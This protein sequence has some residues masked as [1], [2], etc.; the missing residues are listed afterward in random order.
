ME[1]QIKLL[2]YLPESNKI[3][4]QELIEQQK[5]SLAS[6]IHDEKKIIKIEQSCEVTHENQLV[7]KKN[8]N[9]KKCDIISLNL[10]VDK[11]IIIIDNN[12]SSEVLEVLG[13]FDRSKKIIN[14]RLSLIGPCIKHNKKTFDVKNYKQ[15]NDTELNFEI[16]SIPFYKNFDKGELF[17]SNIKKAEYIINTNSCGVK[18][19]RNI[20]VYPDIEITIDVPVS[21]S[22][23]KEITQKITNSKKNAHI[24][25]DKT[26]ELK[27]EAKYKEDG[28][29]WTISPSIQDKFK[30]I[31]DFK[32][33]ADNAFGALQLAFDKTIEIKFE[34]PRGLIHFD[35]KYKNKASPFKVGYEW[36]AQFNLD[37]LI[38]ASA[39]IQLDELFLKTC[40]GPI[41]AL[42]AKIKQALSH[43]NIEVKLELIVTGIL[44]I[45][46]GLKKEISNDTEKGIQG[47]AGITGKI[48]ADLK[49]SGELKIQL[50]I[51]AI[52]VSA[53][54]GAKTGIEA[55]GGIYQNSKNLGL[56]LTLKFLGVTFYFEFKG[57]GGIQSRP[58]NTKDIKDKPLDV[59]KENEITVGEEEWFK[60]IPIS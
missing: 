25:N 29:E 24:Y 16:P 35:Y 2:E 59:S 27:L 55:S 30:N 5:T 51:I 33:I 53:E 11:D 12:G 18:I 48:E 23:S 39:N 13:G 44:K 20:I 3:N 45:D 37:P 26:S 8:T 52:E 58:K 56:D 9:D 60:R 28:H 42:Y 6:G 36:H 41:G 4:K 15:T 7:N 43:L 47:G 50:I 57:S 14:S 40:T 32:K 49:A 1:N 21:F 54:A 17:P 38:G 34:Y 22:E 31:K 10:T 46:S 19:S